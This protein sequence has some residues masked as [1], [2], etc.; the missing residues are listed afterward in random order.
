[1]TNIEITRKS[2]T[3]YILR[4]IF[5]YTKSQIILRTIYNEKDLNT[6]TKNEKPFSYYDCSL[7]TW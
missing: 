1:M 2:M 3:N 4:K 5:Q 6:I 7:F